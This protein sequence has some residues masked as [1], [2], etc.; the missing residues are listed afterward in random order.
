MGCD[1][2]GSMLNGCTPLWVAAQRGSASMIQLLLLR[3][4]GDGRPVVDVNATKENGAS[5][6]YIAAQKGHVDCIRLLARYGASLDLAT[7]D[8][9]W[10]A[11]HIAAQN[12]HVEV[13]GLLHHLGHDLAVGDVEGRTPTHIAGGAQRTVPAPAHSTIT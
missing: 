10:L 12:N 9:G 2:N 4:G 3:D 6:V 8:A 5:P 1:P 11:S 13:I 7:S